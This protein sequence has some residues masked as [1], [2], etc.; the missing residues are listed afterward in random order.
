MLASQGAFTRQPNFE[1]TLVAHQGL[2]LL[3]RLEKA[4][5][6]RQSLTETSPNPFFALRQPA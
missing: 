6:G 2:E 5:R 4:R 1:T 3:V